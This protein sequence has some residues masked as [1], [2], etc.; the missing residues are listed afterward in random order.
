MGT[1]GAWT[2]PAGGLSDC[3]QSIQDLQQ[4][5]PGLG[6]GVNRELLEA[7]EPSSWG[8]LVYF[9]DGLL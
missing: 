2:D 9:E 6:Q 5:N 3:S 8:F 7:A 4:Q 1:S